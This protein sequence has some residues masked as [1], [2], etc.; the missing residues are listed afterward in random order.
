VSAYFRNVDGVTLEGAPQLTSSALFTSSLSREPRQATEII[1]GEAVLVATWTGTLTPSAPASLDLAVQ[2]PVH[3]R[4]HEAAPRVE[5]QNPFPEDVFDALQAN[6]FDTSMFDRFVNQA[7]RQAAPARVHDEAVALRAS[8]RAVDVLAPPATGQPAAFTGAIGR[9]DLNAAVSSA[10]TTVSE[11]VTLR[12][13]VDGDGDLDRVELP[14]VATSADW[15][16]YPAKSVVEPA[17]KGRRARKV[18]EQVLVPLHGGVLAIPPVSLSA[19]DP[20]LGRYVTRETSP[21]PLTVEGNAVHENVP[22]IEASPDSAAAPLVA[23]TPAPTTAPV[24]PRA[25]S[26]RSAA[27]WCSPGLLLV[28]GAMAVAGI[29]RARASRAMRG[30]MRAAAA[31]GEV[32]PF[33]RAAHTLIETRLAERWGMSPHDISPHVIRDHLGPLGEPLAD[34]VDADEALRFGRG[35]L[36]HA[37]LTRL[38]SSIERSLGGAS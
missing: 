12:V 3:L 20:G 13:T 16:A 24:V 15:K 4:Y 6:P 2:L 38:C 1:N 30:R 31:K 28:V 14:G 5:L 23:A 8:A 18:F 7:M 21:L 29:T 36:E 17:V 26:M 22:A 10:R 34:A 11:P 35:H 33:Y 25:V 37:D 27:M 9:F 19:F 32:V